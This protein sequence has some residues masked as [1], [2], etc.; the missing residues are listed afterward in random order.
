MGCNGYT[1]TFFYRAVF[2]TGKTQK[3]KTTNKT[4]N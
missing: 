3:Q 1:T 4:I 2:P